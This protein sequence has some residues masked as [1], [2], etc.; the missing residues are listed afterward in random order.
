MI[1]AIVTAARL[2]QFLASAALFGAPLFFLYAL[3]AVARSTPRSLAWGRSLILASGVILGLGALT[4]LFGQTALMAGDPKLAFD[5]E[6]L[7]M[8]LTGTAFGFAILTRIGLAAVAILTALRLQPSPRLWA[9]AA[10]LGVPILA[11]FAWTGHG[12]AED[13]TAGMLHAAA[14]VVHLLA[15]AVWLGALA[16]FNVLLWPS[17]AP[18]APDEARVLYSALEGFS[19]VGSLVVAALVASGLANSWFLIGPAHLSGLFTTPYGQL[20]LIKLV[21]FIGMLLLAAANRFRL[22]PALGGALG[23]GAG[24]SAA[25]ARLRGS[26]VLEGALGALILLL[27]S[28]L[29]MLAPVAAQA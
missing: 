4:S 14:D 22:T 17:R 10:G 26:L 7:G 15:A 12:A 8:V 6:A 9:A 5:R 28:I 21:L 2:A 3:P 16:V 23:D 25:L 27:V 19:G 13:G 29:G 1:E 18:R 11:S 20:L 24:L